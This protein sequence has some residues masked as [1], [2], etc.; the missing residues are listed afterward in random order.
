MRAKEV[1]NDIIPYRA[2]VCILTILDKN[3]KPDYT[4]SVATEYEFLTSTQTSV[5]RSTETLAN[6]NGQDKEYILD[7]TYNLTVVGNTFNPIFHGVA[8][9]RIEALPTKTLVPKQ[10]TYSLPGSPEDGQSTFSIEFGEGKASEQEPGADSDGNYNFIVEDSYGNT[11]IRS[12]QAYFGT[13][14]YD[15]DTKS[16]HLSSEYANAEIRVIYYY[17]SENSVQYR[18]NPILQQPEYQIDTFGVFQSAGTSE[19]YMVHTRILRGTVTGDVSE[20]TSQKSKS[21]P[22]TYTFKSTPVPEGVSV[23]TQTFTPLENKTVSMDNIVNGLDDDFSDTGTN[24]KPEGPTEND[25]TI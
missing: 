16:I 25:D 22:I 12:E 23:Y 17:E 21:A 6:G 13:Y 14:V 8:T 7:E 18:S 20:Q 19:K 10:F 24:V 4:R 15:S 1:R 3:K 9:G 2:G 11:L 5:S